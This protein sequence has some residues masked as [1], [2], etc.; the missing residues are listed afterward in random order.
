MLSDDHAKLA[1]VLEQLE[2]ER[3][4]R[5]E[6]RVE[7][8]EAVRVPPLSVMGGE[9][10]AK[11]KPLHATLAR[12]ALLRLD[13]MAAPAPHSLGIPRPQF[14]QLCATCLPR[15]P[16]QTVGSSNCRGG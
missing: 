13:L 10:S 5:I 4:R 15:H 12:R 8:R 9:R 7:K 1:A 16:L 14:P 3:Q 2:T 6:E 11:V